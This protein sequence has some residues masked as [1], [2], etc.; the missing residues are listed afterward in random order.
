MCI[1]ESGTPSHARPSAH[2]RT[3]RRRPHVDV[4]DVYKRIEEASKERHSRHIFH[5]NPKR[6]GHTKWLFLKRQRYLKVNEAGKRLI[7]NLE[8]CLI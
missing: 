1:R 5:L 4:P 3:E 2:P 6:V 8:E 7:P